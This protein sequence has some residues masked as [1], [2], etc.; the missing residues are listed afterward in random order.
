M[1]SLFIYDNIIAGILVFVVGFLF[2]WVGQLISIINWEFATKIGLQEAK[3]P[4]E[5]KAYEHA[6]AVA[7]SLIGWIYGLAAVGLILGTEWGYKLAWFP[8][9]ILIYHS[10]SFWFWTGNRKKGDYDLTSARLRIGWTIV[11]FM[12]GSL[13]IVVV[14]YAI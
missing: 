5:Y 7:D 6:I 12:T 11:N 10:I 9:V 3:M 14:W 13:T 2:H 4:K 8:G 1:N